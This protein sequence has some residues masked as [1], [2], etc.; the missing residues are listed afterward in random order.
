M[1]TDRKAIDKRTLAT[2]PAEGV[3]L[4][5]DKETLMACEDIEEGKNPINTWPVTIFRQHALQPCNRTPLEKG[6]DEV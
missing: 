1:V 5:A 3:S 2:C 4:W 6:I